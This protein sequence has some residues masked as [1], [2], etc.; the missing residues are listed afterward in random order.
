MKVTDTNTVSNCF[1]HDTVTVKYDAVCL[2]VSEALAG[3]LV[4]YFPNPN[5][6]TF[7]YELKGFKGM[8]V[9]VEVFS[10]NGQIVYNETLT[11]VSEIETGQIELNSVETGM[12]FIHL[13]T[14]KGSMIHR[15]TVTH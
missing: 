13:R 7:N 2:G 4:S 10:A 1:S 8:D 15:I 3:N 6:G 14:E 12:Y 5:N 9:T 11:D